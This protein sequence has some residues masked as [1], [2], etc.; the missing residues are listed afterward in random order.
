MTATMKYAPFPFILIMLLLCAYG[1]SL[2]LQQLPSNSIAVEDQVLTLEPAEIRII[3]LVSGHAWQN[4]GTEVNE[5]FR[6]AGKN[7]ITRS[8]KTFGFFKEG[9]YI[10]TNVWLCFDG[11]EWFAIVTT[12]FETIGNDK[13]ARLVTAYKVTKDIFP[14]IVEYVKYISEKWGAKEIKYIIEAGEFY[15]RPR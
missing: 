7:G 10:P 9:N 3:E 15:L 14:T 12:I 1:C 2:L 8:F 6:C 13:V 4:H 11:K 5:A